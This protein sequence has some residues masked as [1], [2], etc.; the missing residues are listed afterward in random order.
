[1]TAERA[2]LT[3]VLHDPFADSYA[4]LIEEQFPK[5]CAIVAPDADRLDQYIG[6][7]DVLLAS[8]FPI[9]VLG[10]ATKLRWFQSTAAGMD[11]M[12]PIRD[13]V[14]HITVTN[15]RGIH[16]QIIADFVMA[17][18]TMLQWNF[19][20]FLRE[21][22]QRKWNPRYVAPLAEKTLGAIGLGSIGKTIAQRAK[23]AGMTVIGTKR[24]ISVPIEGVDHLFASDALEEVL[25]LCDFVV[26]ALPATR[27]TKG[28]IGATEIARIR[29]H[30]FLI[31]VARGASWW[32]P[33]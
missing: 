6:E 19:H 3:I 28:L 7:A 9:H 12:L 18:V 14:G 26:L 5:V 29:P 21:Q 10:K 2:A 22:S 25:P 11:S 24:D 32:K 13:L 16:G 8:R 15:A 31:N 4:R 20:L 1:M 33:N 23:S 30:A 17:G 27:E